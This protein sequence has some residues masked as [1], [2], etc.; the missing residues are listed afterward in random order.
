MRSPAPLMSN[1]TLALPWKACPSSLFV[2][3]DTT[4]NEPWTGEVAASCVRVARRSVRA[5]AYANGAIK[6]TQAIGCRCLHVDV[7]GWDV[8]KFRDFCRHR[9]AERCE[10][11]LLGDDGDVDVVDFRIH[12]VD[13]PLR[14]CDKTRRIS[15]FPL[16]IV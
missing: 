4:S 10:L 13:D 16:R 15:A 2:L 5:S 14:L 9:I 7:T 11:R 12:L 8:E 3:V 1:P 6:K